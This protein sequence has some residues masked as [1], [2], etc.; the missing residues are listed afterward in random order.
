MNDKK[1]SSGNAS[2]NGSAGSLIRSVEQL[3]Y[4]ILAS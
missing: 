3:V 4:N 1:S 2:S